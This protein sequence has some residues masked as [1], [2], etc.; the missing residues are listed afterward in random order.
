MKYST[1][2]FFDILYSMRDCKK[3]SDI[4]NADDFAAECESK[5]TALTKALGLDK[6]K[7]I[8]TEMTYSRISEKQ[9]DMEILPK[10]VTPVWILRPNHSNGKTILYLP[11]HDSYG[12]R[13]SFNYYGQN[14]TFHKWLP[15]QLQGEGYTVV[16]PELI[17]FGEVIN[18]GYGE[19]H[20]GCYANTE[21][22]LM[23]GITMA[24][25]RMYQAQCAIKL[26]EEVTGKPV[27]GLY[28][29]SGGA[30]VAAVLAA[31]DHSFESVVISNYGATF[32]SS[33]MAMHH[34]VDNYIPGLLNIGE[35]SD[36]LGLIAPTPL[37]ITNGE[38]DTIFPNEGVLITE[39]ELQKIYDTADAGDALYCHN[40]S[41]AHETNSDAVIKFYDSFLPKARKKMA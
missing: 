14:Q 27:T 8:G 20:N 23:Y 12:A 32:K 30:L 24:G 22:L 2:Y 25:M 28:G 6:I 36:I 11:G 4:D 3:L 13:G 5:R 38:H 35:I 37:M 40:H 33:I 15:L 7:A 31:L 19:K 9:F 21:M 29:I 17:G 26:A 41:G 1:D 16:I 18:E 10:L 39:K 34:C